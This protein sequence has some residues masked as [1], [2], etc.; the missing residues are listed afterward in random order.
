MHNF[1]GHFVHLL[2]IVML[3]LLELVLPTALLEFDPQLPGIPGLPFSLEYL[4]KDRQDHHG[5][6]L[7]GEVDVK[8]GDQ[9]GHQFKVVHGGINPLIGVDGEVLHDVHELSPD[10]PYR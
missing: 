7:L 4:V 5:Q 3:Q 8:V 9:L 6:G 10:C 2:V 1:R